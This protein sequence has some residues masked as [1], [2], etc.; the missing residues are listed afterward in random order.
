MYKSHEIKDGKII[1]S[2]DHIGDG[3]KVK[4]KYGHVN[5]FAIAGEDKKFVWAMAKLKGDNVVVWNEK[6]TSPQYVRF[7]WGDNPDDLN[8]YNSVG[9]PACPFRIGE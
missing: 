3:L 7:G 5:G 6:I 2:F 8:L 1:I 9:L 4:N